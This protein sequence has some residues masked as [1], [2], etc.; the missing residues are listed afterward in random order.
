[1]K[2]TRNLLGLLFLVVLAPGCPGGGGGGGGTPAPVTLSLEA[3]Q[4]YF[5][6]ADGSMWQFGGTIENGAPPVPF[7]NA[8]LCSGT[9]MI[10]SVST[11]VVHRTNADNL[12]PL[13]TYLVMDAG[14]ITH[15]GNNDPTDFLTPQVVPYQEIRFPIV[16]NTPYQ[17][18]NRNGL[19]WAQDLDGDGK[20]ESAS[21]VVT[22]T[23]LGPEDVTLPLATFP[24]CLKVQTV[25]SIVVTLSSNGQQLGVT[26]VETDWFATGIGPVQITIQDFFS[27]GTQSLETEQLSAYGI[28]ASGTGIISGFDTASGVT[29]ANSDVTMPGRPAL[30]TDGVHTLMVSFTDATT[31]PGLFGSMLTPYG[32]P[33]QT[34]HLVD[35][36]GSGP[37]VGNPA[38]ALM[39]SSFLVAFGQSGGAIHGVRVGLDGTPLDASPGFAISSG[40]TSLNRNDSLPSVASSGSTCLVTYVRWNNGPSLIVGALVA[41]DGTVLSEFPISAQGSV[42]YPTVSF[43]GT[44]FLVLWQD[45]RNSATPG[46]GSD[47]YAARVNLSGTVLDPSGIPIC[48]APG[49][50]VQPHLLFDGTQYFAVWLDNRLDSANFHIYGARILP[51]GT[52][53]DGTVSSSGLLINA[54]PGQKNNPR[55]GRLGTD[56]FITWDIAAPANF[57]PAGIFGARVT[58]AGVLRD[59]PTSGSGV[60][61]S[62]PPTGSAVFAYPEL[63]STGSGTLVLWL[64]CEETLGT[65]KSIEEAMVYPF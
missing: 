60:S 9:K 49:D 61:V 51:D 40:N 42:G 64:D 6:L 11:L 3:S 62:G 54:G 43:D 17:T 50:Q 21:M 58:T 45:S 28:G 14:G 25:T 37:S 41:T 16:T 44:N 53:L 56:Y 36:V 52:V 8:D 10:G 29:V 38:A 55:V 24:A 18:I 23:V 22:V 4:G 33:L 32:Q 5:P 34:F 65:R 57:P 7:S 47:L 2:A 15:W 1:M 26:E 39:G 46:E 12:G 35:S 48:Q 63:H 31:P 20:Y 19:V 13:E 30:A 27:D 59:G